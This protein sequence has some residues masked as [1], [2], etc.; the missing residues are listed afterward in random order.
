MTERRSLPLR[1]GIAAGIAAGLCLVAAA[2]ARTGEAADERP[3]AVRFVNVAKEAGLTLLNHSGS[4]GKDTINE[5]VGNGVCLADFDDDGF[6]DIFLPNGQPAT[7][8]AARSALYRARGDGT[9]EDRT[10][11]SGA[12][13]AGFWAQGCVAADYD[14]DGRIDLFVT[15]FGRYWLLKQ[16]APLRFA[17][18]TA[19]AGLSGGRGWSTGAA[20]ADYDGDG[21]IDLWVS[22]YVDYDQDSPPLP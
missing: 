18:V 17:D 13:L 21:W 2:R 6:L 8:A 19:A 9:Y 20:F 14:A 5:T 3:P 4:P 15:G 10:D 7:G 12:A 16:T 11:G 22:H 1:R